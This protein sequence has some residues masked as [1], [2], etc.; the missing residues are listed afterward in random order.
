MR[1]GKKRRKEGEKGKEI[2][3]QPLFSLVS[4]SCDTTQTLSCPL[5]AAW[6]TSTSP[7]ALLSLSPCIYS[8]VLNLVLISK[9][10]NTAIKLGL[11]PLEDFHQSHQN[12]K[13]EQAKLSVP[14]NARESV[15]TPIPDG[16][17]PNSTELLSLSR[18]FLT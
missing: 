9:I 6:E 8:Q 10:T 14:V 7:P 11:R 5:L 18:A 4:L 2:G 1:K 12:I 16:L 3:R 17:G 13:E 15:S